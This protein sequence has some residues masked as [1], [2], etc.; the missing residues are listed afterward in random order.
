MYRYY[1]NPTVPNRVTVVGNYSNGVLS[2]SASRCSNKDQFM[3]KRGRT[4]AESRLEKGKTI[5][6]VEIEDFSIK[7]FI[8]IARNVSDKIQ[9]EPSLIHTTL[10]HV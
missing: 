1:S 10:N 3:R 8:E 5:L 9:K 7:N 2:V 6:S 4:I